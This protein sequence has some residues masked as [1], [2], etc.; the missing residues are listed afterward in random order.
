MICICVYMYVRAGAQRGQKRA[1]DHWRW[2]SRRLWAA[3]HDCWDMNMGSLHE[4]CVILTAEPSLQP[5]TPLTFFSNFLTN[6]P[7]VLQRHPG[8][9]GLG[10]S[11]A[12]SCF[13]AQLLSLPPLS[14]ALLLLSLALW[15][16]IRLLLP[17]HL[18][19]TVTHRQLLTCHL[20]QKS[21]FQEILIFFPQNFSLGVGESRHLVC[22]FP[23]QEPVTLERRGWLPHQ[24][25]LWLL[26]AAGQPQNKE[27]PTLFTWRWPPFPWAGAQSP[28]CLLPLDT[29]TTAAVMPIPLAN[30]HWWGLLHPPPRL[31]L[32]KQLRELGGDSL[33]HIPL[34]QKIAKHPDEHA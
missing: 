23:L 1:L 5:P 26:P 8:E 16:K 14:G 25:V 31:H 20:T 34:L 13:S 30:S 3:Q 32:L 4:Q 7:E 21:H 9:E 28:G 24:A 17:R 19:F 2:S 27:V 18:S 6:T 22:A 29:V 15:N 10:G 11:K 12:L 33:E